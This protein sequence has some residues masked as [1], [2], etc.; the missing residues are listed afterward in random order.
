MAAAYRLVSLFNMDDL[1]STHLSAH[2][3]GEEHRFLLNPY[4]WCWT[5][6]RPRALWSSTQKGMRSRGRTYP[7]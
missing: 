5:R 3:P 6:S 4:G 2:L 1:I 7:R